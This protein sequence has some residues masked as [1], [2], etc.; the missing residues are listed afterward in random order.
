MHALKRCALLL[1]P[2]TL[3]IGALM[4]AAVASARTSSV[5]KALPSFIILETLKKKPK[6]QHHKKHHTSNVVAFHQL[7]DGID[8]TQ[9]SIQQNDVGT[10]TT[11]TVVGSSLEARGVYDIS[12]DN[13][14]L[15]NCDGAIL[16][17]AIAGPEPI[18]TINGVVSFSPNGIFDG[19]ETDAGPQVV[20]AFPS[21][22]FSTGD[23]RADLEGRITFSVEILNCVKNSY[24]IAIQNDDR[25]GDG[26]EIRFPVT[27][28]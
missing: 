15:D 7:H 23:I 24:T 4:P 11:F 10:P 20:G 2:F 19:G 14:T 21:T 5:H 17:G 26:S 22:D 18:T 12:L 1:I 16:L 9:G 6:H 28:A 25:S 27:S 3:L 8:I 13:F